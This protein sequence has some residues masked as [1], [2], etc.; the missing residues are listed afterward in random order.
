MK[1]KGFSLVE[2]LLTISIISIVVCGGTSVVGSFKA[3]NNSINVDLCSSSL[4]SMINSSKL[5]CR[6]K[7][8]PGY[9]L[10]DLRNNNI[11]F[12]C[13]GVRVDLF[14]FP[15]GFELYSINSADRKIR[16]DNQGITGDACTIQYKDSKNKLHT[17]TISVGTAYAEIKN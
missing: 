16:F 17:L 3:Y 6:S 13:Q 14:E 12:F 15:E 4:L 7:E 9:L 8:S 2:L 5:Y 11:K 1:H 10:F